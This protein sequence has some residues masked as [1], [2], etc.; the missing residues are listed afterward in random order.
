MSDLEYWLQKADKARSYA[1]RE[2]WHTALIIT[3]GIVQFLKE[4][5]PTHLADTGTDKQ[6]YL[7]ARLVEETQDLL[8]LRLRCKR[9]DDVDVIVKTRDEFCKLLA[10]N[11]YHIGREDNWDASDGTECSCDDCHNKTCSTYGPLGGCRAAR[12]RED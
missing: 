5:I 11:H 10:D 3:V 2:K 4:K 8:Q 7:F 1:Q 12:T 6:K 9:G